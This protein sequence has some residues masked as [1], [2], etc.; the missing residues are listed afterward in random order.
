[1]LP[2]K[3]IDCYDENK[4][5]GETENT[6]SRAIFYKCGTKITIRQQVQSCVTE[7]KLKSE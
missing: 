1:M 2:V 5:T 6:Q 7:N 4:L 3:A